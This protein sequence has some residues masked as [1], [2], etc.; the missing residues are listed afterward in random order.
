MDKAQLKEESAKDPADAA[1]AVGQYLTDAFVK[2]N[3]SLEKDRSID[4][5]VSPPPAQTRTVPV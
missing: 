1:E 4:S 2:V 3:N 5:S